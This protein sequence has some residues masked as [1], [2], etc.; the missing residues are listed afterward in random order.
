[1]EGGIIESHL[2]HKHLLHVPYISPSAS[3]RGPGAVE[4]YVRERLEVT[5]YTSRQS[6]IIHGKVHLLTLI[7]SPVRESE[8]GPFMTE[9]CE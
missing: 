5:G 1:M 7:L 6:I 8:R 4:G 9:L 3:S 2:F